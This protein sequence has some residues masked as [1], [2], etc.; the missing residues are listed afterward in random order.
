MNR[1]SLLLV[2]AA[3]VAALLAI[4]FLADVHADRELLLVVT[5]DTAVLRDFP[6][7]P[8][9]D[10]ASNVVIAT[11]HA[12]QP[13][14]VLRVRYGKD[15]QAVKVR[16]PDGLTGWVIT[17]PTSHLEQPA[18]SRVFTTSPASPQHSASRLST[19][20]PIIGS[21]LDANRPRSLRR[22]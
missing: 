5:A 4:A 20:A 7:R 17:G 10:T 14:R 19:N 15:F 22:T 3:G 6:T 13:S 2:I 1:I 11:I 9:S 8:N 12:G 21:T 16:L 18:S